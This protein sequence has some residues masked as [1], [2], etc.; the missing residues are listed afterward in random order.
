MIETQREKCWMI[1]HYDLSS[2]R[3]ESLWRSAINTC[4]V[5]IGKAGTHQQQR[6]ASNGDERQSLYTPL[7]E[8]QVQ[9]CRAW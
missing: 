6:T 7:S 5:F 1:S 3:V 9:G 4:S 8:N 2:N